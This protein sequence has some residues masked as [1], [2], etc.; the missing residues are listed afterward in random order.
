M[1]LMMIYNFKTGHR[2]LIQVKK[3]W[4]NIDVF[5]STAPNEIE[6]VLKY[7]KSKP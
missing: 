4:L 5:R 7:F 6:K 1:V 2:K 3:G